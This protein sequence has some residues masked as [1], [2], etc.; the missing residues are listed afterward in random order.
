MK[1]LIE[2]YSYDPAVVKNILPESRFLLT[3]KKAKID[4]SMC[5]GCGLCSQMCRFG[6]L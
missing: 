2:G 4:E 6:A 3:D 5:V 1:V